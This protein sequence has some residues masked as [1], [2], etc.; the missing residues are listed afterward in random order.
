[1]AETEATFFEVLFQLARLQNNSYV[2]LGEGQLLTSVSGTDWEV[3]ALPDDFAGKSMVQLPDE[4]LLVCG[5]G[6][7]ML[8]AL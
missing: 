8:V 5:T 1:M 2:A 7:A 4:R 3:L 6:E